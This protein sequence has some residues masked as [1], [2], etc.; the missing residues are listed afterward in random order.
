LR[1]ARVRV[2]NA[3]LDGGLVEVQAGEVA[4]VGGVAQAQ[5]DAVGAAVNGGA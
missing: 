2:G 5:V 4:R 1:A 3:G